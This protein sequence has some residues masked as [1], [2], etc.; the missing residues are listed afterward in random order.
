MPRKQKSVIVHLRIRSNILDDY[1]EY[2]PDIPDPAPVK[3]T[4]SVPFEE[5]ISCQI[6][7]GDT[8]LSSSI[9]QNDTLDE[10]RN[11]YLTSIS[12]QKSLNQLEQQTQ[13][14][15]HIQQTQQNQLNSRD[16]NGVF[17]CNKEHTGSTMYPRGSQTVCW[18]EGYSFNTKPCF[19]PKRILADGTY[20]VYGNFCSPECAM[21]Y[22]ENEG[23]ID[24]ET[25]WERCSMLHETT[26][27][28]YSSK[29]DR[30]KSA[31]P[32]WALR[33]YG[34]EFTIEEFRKLNT[35]PE[36]ACEMYYPPITTD[37]PI[38]RIKHIPQT[39]KVRVP[40]N[41]KVMIQDDR[42]QKAAMN[43]H[44]SKISEEPTKTIQ[45]KPSIK[46]GVS[47]KSRGGLASMMN[48]RIVESENVSST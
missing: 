5:Y 2:V 37:T 33:E 34:G 7:D 48:I 26:H 18:W 13:P 24:N 15:Q 12:L 22:L 23:D 29:V 46:Q 36:S 39:H 32:R 3:T 38:I 8:T 10:A 17:I 20:S 42:F 9:L 16:L 41:T 14:N 19:I 40:V 44:A 30:I 27:K 45:V 1:L 25:R 11:M 21:A 43:I 31:L 35:F 47:L 6:G 4:S 28:T